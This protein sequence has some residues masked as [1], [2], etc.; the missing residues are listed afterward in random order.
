MLTNEIKDFFSDK[1]VVITGGTGLVGRQLLELLAPVA[2]VVSSISLDD[3]EPVK[4]VNY[5]KADLRE[6][7]VCRELIDEGDIVFHVAGIKGNPDVTSSNVSTMF[8]PYLQFNTNVLEACRVQ[9]AGRVVYTSTIGAYSSKEIFVEEGIMDGKPMDTW[10]GWAKR[11]AEAQIESYK[12]QY[13]LK[14]FIACRLANI[15]GPG[16]NF[17]PDNAMVIPSL[18]FK[19][20]NDWQLQN[21]GVNVWGDGS[22][23]RDFAFSRDIA[24]GLI[25]A[26]FVMPDVQYMNLGSGIGVTIRELVYALNPIAGGFGY[27]FDTTKP[28]GFPKR[29]MD[30]SLAKDLIGYNP[31]TSLKDGLKETWEWFLQNKQEYLKRKNYFKEN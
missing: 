27:Q 22:P 31:E 21:Q 18:M 20:Y 24:E 30:I 4:K 7:S 16:D 2:G 5:V 15:Y 28:N 29:I 26:A 19:I 9:K 14:N 11:M 23:V 10:A 6:F 8:V 13:G 12:I 1:S 25:R 17:D 3:L